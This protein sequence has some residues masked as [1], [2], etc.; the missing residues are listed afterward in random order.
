M[1]FYTHIL[2]CA[3]LSE[4]S[5]I[6]AHRALE[7]A[8]K[9]SAKLTMMHVVESLPAYASGYLGVADVER[10]LLE[11]AKKEMKKIAAT[12]NIPSE[13]QILVIGNPAME[14]FSKAETLKADLIVVGS[15]EKHGLGRFLGSNASGILHKAHC[16]VLTVKVQAE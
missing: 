2:F 12:L 14:I 8:K 15:H 4:H 5:L 6:S 1:S 3:D 13:N 11:T 16:D 7:L 9:F 10:E